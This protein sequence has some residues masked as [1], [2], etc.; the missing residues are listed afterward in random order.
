M[1]SPLSDLVRLHDDLDHVCVLVSSSDRTR[2]VFNQ[3]FAH[4]ERFWPECAFDRYVGLT[5]VPQEHSLFGFKPVAAGSD[6]GWRDELVAQLR[7]LPATLDYVLLVLD[8]FLILKP[9]NQSL[10]NKAAAE[11]ISRQLNYARFIPVERHLF[12]RTLRW[13]H[14]PKNHIFSPLSE[15]EPYPASL[16]IALWRKEY[17]LRSLEAPGTIW[18][19]EHAR[20][21]QDGHFAACVPLIS[22]RHVVERGK[23]MPYANHLMKRVGIQFKKGTRDIYPIHYGIKWYIGKIFFAIAGYGPSK[24]KVLILRKL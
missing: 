14:R 17:L 1:A 11:V 2:D 15:R 8:D 24:L 9:I 19:F 10:L 7:Q 12:G 21:Q 6:M 18:D 3:V 4:F 16:Q 22:Y 23:W 20:L 13:L 5:T